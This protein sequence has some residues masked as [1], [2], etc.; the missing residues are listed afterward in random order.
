MIAVEHA[1]DRLDRVDVAIL[2]GE[3]VERRTAVM[4][5]AP[6]PFALDLEQGTEMPDQPVARHDAA[7]EEILRDPVGAVAVIEAV[8]RGAVAEDVQEQLAPGREPAADAAEE[9][10][11]IR[12]V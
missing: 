12:P 3:P 2:M 6:A 11:P 9:R 1:Q 7:G 4:I 5:A 10:R 8:R